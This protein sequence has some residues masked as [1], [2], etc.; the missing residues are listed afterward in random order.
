MWVV[1]SNM[2][3]IQIYKQFLK[4]LLSGIDNDTKKKNAL[5]DTNITIIT[6]KTWLRIKSSQHIN[7]S[8][9]PEE[10]RMKWKMASG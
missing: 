5:M 9:H 2:Y 1:F 10:L 3:S 4:K 7:S 6:N 8:D